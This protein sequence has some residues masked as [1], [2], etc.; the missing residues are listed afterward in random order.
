MKSLFGVLLL[1]FVFAGVFFYS[2]NPIKNMAPSG[3]F[4][5]PVNIG[6]ESN[7]VINF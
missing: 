4:D 3:D 7:E 1:C 6:V 2:D 5:E